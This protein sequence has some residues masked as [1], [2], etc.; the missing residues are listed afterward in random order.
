MAHNFLTDDLTAPYRRDYDCGL[1]P[2]CSYGLCGRLWRRRLGVRGGVLPEDV[3]Y[4][5]V[6]GARFSGGH[7]REESVHFIGQSDTELYCFHDTMI[8]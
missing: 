6:Q 1:S 7:P 4:L 3:E 5:P 2:D 8:H